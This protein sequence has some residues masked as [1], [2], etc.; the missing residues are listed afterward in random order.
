MM[1]LNWGAVHTLEGIASNGALQLEEQHDRKVMKSNE[2]KSKVPA[3]GWIDPMHQD[4]LG[5]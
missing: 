3:L 2:S 1:K 5:V 4:R